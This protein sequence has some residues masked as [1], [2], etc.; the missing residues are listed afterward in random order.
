MGQLVN[1]TSFQFNGTVV[2]TFSVVM[3]RTFL[4]IF[5]VSGKAGGRFPAVSCFLSSFI[6]LLIIGPAVMAVFNQARP[7]E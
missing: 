5:R 3:S 2:E 1:H 6:R 7:P 4:E